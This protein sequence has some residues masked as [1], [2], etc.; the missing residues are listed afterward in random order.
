MIPRGSDRKSLGKQLH[1]DRLRFFGDI[2]VRRQRANE[3][4]CGQQGAQ[5]NSEGGR[6]YEAIIAQQSENP[7]EKSENLMGESENL[8]EAM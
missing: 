8:P 1:H 5:Q 7:I 3:A 4:L 2:V 6:Q